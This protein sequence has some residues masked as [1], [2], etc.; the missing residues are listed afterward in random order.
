MWFYQRLRTTDPPETEENIS[1]R[2]STS[3]RKDSND[4]EEL[5]TNPIHLRESQSEIS[6]SASL[7]TSERTTDLFEPIHSPIIRNPPHKPLRVCHW[8][9]MLFIFS[10]SFLVC[11]LILFFST[12]YDAIYAQMT[13]ATEDDIIEDSYVTYPSFSQYMKNRTMKN[14]SNGSFPQVFSVLLYGDSLIEFPTED[15]DLLHRIYQKLSYNQSLYTV[16]LTS[17]GKGGDRSD[18][19]LAKLPIAM[20]GGPY[21]AAILYWDSDVSDQSFEDLM[22]PST[23]HTFKE[24]VRSIISQIRDVYN[25]TYLA[26]SG[27]EL[28]GEGPFYLKPQFR[29]KQAMLDLYRGMNQEVCK[30]YAVPYINYRRAC[31]QSIPLY[32]WFDQ[33]ILTK[34]GE[35][36]N[37]HG[38]EF[39]STFLSKM[40]N[41][42]MMSS[43]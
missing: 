15:N 2:V 18:D 6:T 33:G 20:S 23:Q 12:K 26:L 28:L 31:L 21:D 8:E 11:W 36:P 24:N 5:E 4:A 43:P 7:R 38:A 10:F 16:Q 17:V 30:D 1:N 3:F 41:K 27:P 39:M 19:L 9:R 13:Y 29:Y 42:W 14:P 25:V 34:D 22:H 32:W 37:D 35:H 40:I